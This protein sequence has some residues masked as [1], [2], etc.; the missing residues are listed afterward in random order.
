MVGY[1]TEVYPAQG[2]S[3]AYLTLESRH[4]NRLGLLH[5]GIVSMLLDVACGNTASANFDP[6]NH[7]TL[8]TV[9]LN[10]TYIAPARNGRVVATGRYVGGGKTMAYVNG[11]LH[12][13]AGTLLATASAV[14]KRVKT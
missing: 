13:Q 8:V 10:T 3:R 4:L 12:D 11:E 1:E 9:S 6:V 2:Y 5:G 7:A 14:F